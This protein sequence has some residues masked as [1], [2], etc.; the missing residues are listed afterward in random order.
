MVLR[1]AGAAYAGPLSGFSLFLCVCVYVRGKCCR[2]LLY[3]D[4]VHARK[5]EG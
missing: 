4:V 1:D 5:K 2:A 3:L